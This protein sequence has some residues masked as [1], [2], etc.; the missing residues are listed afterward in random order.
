[1]WPRNEKATNL[2]VMPSERQELG[3]AKLKRA[4]AFT[5]QHH[6]RRVG[7]GGDWAVSKRAILAIV[8][9]NYLNMLNVFTLDDKR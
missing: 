3:L 8:R 6:I 4:A 2:S 1:M 9:A 7:S 5:A